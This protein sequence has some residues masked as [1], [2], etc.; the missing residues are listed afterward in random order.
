MKQ[1]IFG[2]VFCMSGVQSDFSDVSPRLRELC[3][4][5]SPHFLLTL[6]NGHLKDEYLVRAGREGGGM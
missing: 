2:V 1:T 5:M 6:T 4:L 3:E